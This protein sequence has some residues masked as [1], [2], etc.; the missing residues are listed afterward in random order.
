[1]K[2]EKRLKVQRLNEEAKARKKAQLNEEKDEMQRLKDEVNYYNL[3]YD[4]STVGS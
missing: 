1:M 2:D 3:Q 4:K